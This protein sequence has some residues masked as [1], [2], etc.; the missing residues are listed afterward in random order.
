MNSIISISKTL[1]PFPDDDD[2]QPTPDEKQ[3]GGSTAG[4][5]HSILVDGINSYPTV[6]PPE[7]VLL[8]DD[9]LRLGDIAHFI[10]TAGAGKSVAMF[11]MAISWGLG[12]PYMGIKPTRPLR[13]LIFSG[14]DD[15]TT[16]GQ[17]REGF[18][19]NA[20]T[21]TGVDVAA[22]DLARLDGMIRTEFSRE[23]V[24]ERFHG[25]LVKLLADFPAD[26]V[27]INPLLSY[28]G[29]EVVATVSTWLRAGL[30]PILQAHKCAA[31][32]AHHTPKMS[33]DGWDTTDDTY[34]AIGGG[35]VAN[36]P[37]AILTLRPTPADG[38]SVVT[39]SKR[40]TIGWRDDHEKYTTKYFVR[41]SGNP[42]RP[43]WIPVPF[44]E[45]EDSIGV[46][47]SRAKTKADSKCTSGHVEAA[48]QAG[49]TMRQA[50]I[51]RL[52]VKCQ[53][54]SRTAVEAITHAEGMGVI[55]SFNETNPNGGKALK[56]LRL[57][58]HANQ[59]AK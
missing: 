37:R 25:H 20:E 8:G 50:L 56:W 30:M 26:L 43:A 57:P 7:T 1:P 38:I 44:D 29:G 45:A 10:S 58:E 3:E 13:I 36:I 46:T 31:L 23:Y 40:Q 27:L 12:L 5:D 24:G 52:M 33:K 59:G 34:S 28:L 19:E 54:S 6:V 4:T 21:I 18:L 16:I 15:G 48:L 47:K 14:E 9:W 35:E 2:D 51:E 41:R 42:F 39:V 17:C 11:Q 22:Q 53:C 32:I 55:S 49:P